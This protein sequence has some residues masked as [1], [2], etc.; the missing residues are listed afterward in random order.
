MSRSD[1]RD[2]MERQQ[3]QKVSHRHFKIEYPTLGWTSSPSPSFQP[4]R[5][6]VRAPA[7]RTEASPQ[8][9]LTIRG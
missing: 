2:L 4:R 5:N 7:Q 8:C 9:R 6:E 1:L 3:P